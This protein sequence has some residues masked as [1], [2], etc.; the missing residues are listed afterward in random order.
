[1][2]APIMSINN[3]INNLTAGLSGVENAS[4]I[5]TG[6]FEAM[7]QQVQMANAAAEQLNQAMILAGDAVDQNTAGQNRFNASVG[8]GG[9]AA[10][11]LV[12]KIGAAVAAYA[13][14]QAIKNVLNLSDEIAQTTARLDM[15][16]DGLRS[17]QDMQNRIF[18]SAQRSRG[19]YLETADAVSKLGVL[20]GNAFSSND[21]IIAFVE[22][23]NKAF[24]IGSQDIQTQQ[25]AM[26]QL[27][28]A[29]G[30]GVLRGDELVSVMEGA[31]IL[32]QSIAKY[33]G[34]SVGEMKNLAAESLV[35][36]DV[37]KNAMLGAAKDTNDVFEEMPKTFGQVAQSVK[38]QAI[39]AFQ[40]ILDRL[41]DIAN[42]PE[43]QTFADNVVNAFAWL[44][45]A[46]S[47]A[48]DGV[49]WAV[50]QLQPPLAAIAG[51]VNGVYNSFVNNW[52]RIAPVINFAAGALT[53]VVGVILAYRAAVAAAA[54]A[55]GVMNAAL[56]ACPLTWIIIAV[57]AVVGAIYAVVAGVNKA[58]GA[59]ISA[60]GVIFGAFAWLGAVVAN[61]FMEL[62]DFILDII[63]ALVNPFIEIANFIGN[64]FTNPVSSIIYLFQG[65]V[66][67]VLALLQTVAS[68][69]DLVFG[70][71]FK[72]A[73]AGWRSGLRGM[74]DAAVAALAPN[75]DYT[76]IMD[77]L[78]L[79]VSNTLGWER[80]DGA[81][82][83]KAGY[84]AGEDLENALVN[85]DPASL[86]GGGIDMPPP[87]PGP[88]FDVPTFDEMAG[89]LNN[90]D[91]NTKSAADYSE[92]ELK[93]WRDIAER[94]AVNRFTTADLSINFGGITNNVSSEMNLDGIVDYIAEN[95]EET[96]GI[97]AGAYA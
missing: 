23:A 92:E 49:I 48:I 6:S 46:A 28:Q 42:S 93:L 55:Q 47:A 34:V 1:M 45:Q 32:A 33:M 54:I 27:T 30:A 85:F 73:I 82:A 94:D 17:T 5:D 53:A 87:D 3:A 41:N 9:S 74:A 40:P 26:R 91:A 51:W 97:V 60:T 79:S 67:N 63:N 25:A 77:S 62:L 21:E 11:G 90:I 95:V 13:S 81:D 15:M 75:E 2:T 50:N 39:M 14:I 52:A 18:L 96:L 76:R 44:A 78:D 24:A 58:A 12:K 86:F 38:N 71:S 43:F 4:D 16:N 35:T 70:S 7:R 59:T 64:V 80:L 8:R 83:Y 72:A 29:M 61:V 89:S 88:M 37:V 56:W 10:G 31:P 20:A 69:L 65:M 19:A 36:A 66:D 68:A 22:Q 84:K 57:V